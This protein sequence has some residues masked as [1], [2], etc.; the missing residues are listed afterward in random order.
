MN[1]QG[2]ESLTRLRKNVPNK[3]E[4]S[5]N[6]RPASRKKRPS[7]ASVKGGSN[8]VSCKQHKRGE[9]ID[10]YSQREELIIK[11]LGKSR[12]MFSCKITC[13]ARCFKLIFHVN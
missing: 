11:A 13:I 3:T 9:S 1:E 6:P 8:D 10:H 5:P 7:P 12:L 2:Q 4:K